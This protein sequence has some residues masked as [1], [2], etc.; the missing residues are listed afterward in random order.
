MRPLQPIQE[1]RKAR[2]LFIVW[3][4]DLTSLEG[5]ELP[6]SLYVQVSIMEE[7]REEREEGM[8]AIIPVPLSNH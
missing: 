2:I 8:L 4:G 3:E 1:F 5:D 7:R 6:R